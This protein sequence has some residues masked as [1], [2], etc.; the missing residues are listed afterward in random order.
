MRAY[1]FAGWMAAALL[2]MAGCDASSGG[3]D[4]SPPPIDPGGTIDICYTGDCGGAPDVPVPQDGTVQPDT[5]GQDV[6]NPPD[7]GK[8]AGKDPGTTDPGQDPGTP[9]T[10]PG[11][12]ADPGPVDTYVDPGPPCEYPVSAYGLRDNCDGTL[13]DTNSGRTWQKGMGFSADLNAARNTCLGLNAERLGGFTD[14]H[15]PTIDE[16][17]SLVL[18][19]DAK[20]GPSGAC[21]VH[22]ATTDPAKRTADCNGCDMNQGPVVNPAKPTSRCYMDSAFDWYCN[23]YW[24]NT[25]IQATSTGDLRAWYL[26]FYDAAINVPPPGQSMGSAAVKCVRGP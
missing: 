8:D 13:T 12:P 7:P 5:T 18:G 23:L 14:W 22:S 20:T 25:Q 6:V 3:R 26:T 17:R 10:D 1:R 15:L 9:P 11:T 4:D 16:L 2:A 19:C 21:P 24:S